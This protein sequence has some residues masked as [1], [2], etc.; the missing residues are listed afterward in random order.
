[1]HARW[2]ALAFLGL[3]W[4]SGCGASSVPP[5]P[6]QSG[7]PHPKPTALAINPSLISLANAAPES[8]APD[9]RNNVVGAAVFRNTCALCHGPGIAGAPRLDDQADW[10]IRVARGVDTLYAHA[11]AGY[12]GQQGLMPSRGGNP[13]LSDDEVR[14]AVDYMVSRSTSVLAASPRNRS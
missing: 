4:L 2:Q 12:K 13:S 8:L 3:S 14:S 5:P 11:I 1:M 9:E 6:R 10:S 7:A